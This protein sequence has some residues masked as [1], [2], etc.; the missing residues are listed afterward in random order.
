MVVFVVSEGLVVFV[1]VVPEGLAVLAW[2]AALGTL[3]KEEILVLIPFKER[4]K[5]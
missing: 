2:K 1:V 3:R 5:F 4:G